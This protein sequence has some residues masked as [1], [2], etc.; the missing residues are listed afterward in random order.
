LTDDVV[1]RWTYPNPTGGPDLTSDIAGTTGQIF[2]VNSD[3]D[4]AGTGASQGVM[5]LDE[6]PET[7]GIISHEGTYA[8]QILLTGDKVF[9]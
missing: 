9:M 7:S 1:V 2:F 5:L 4:P 3:G 8:A 6:D